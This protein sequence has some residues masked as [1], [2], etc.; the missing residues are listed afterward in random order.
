M[1]KE[2]FEILS[3]LLFDNDADFI[4][5]VNEKGQEHAS[6]GG[7]IGNIATMLTH[8]FTKVKKGDNPSMAEKAFVKLIK[9]AMKDAEAV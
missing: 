3:K 5:L 4:L 7:E 8:I 6:L 9:N 2:L 1:I